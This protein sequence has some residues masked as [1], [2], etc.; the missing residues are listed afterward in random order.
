MSA[1]RQAVRDGTL[2]HHPLPALQRDA[3][4]LSI[5]RDDRFAEWREI[6]QA[7]LYLLP[8]ELAFVAKLPSVQEFHFS[9]AFMIQVHQ[10]LAIR[11]KPNESPRE[12]VITALALEGVAMEEPDATSKTVD[13]ANHA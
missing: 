13:G 3:L 7:Q 8:R 5:S 6:V 1:E 2:P 12:N 11:P 4:D 9:E 10:I